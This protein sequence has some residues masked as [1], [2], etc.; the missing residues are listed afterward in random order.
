MP[1]HGT[2]LRQTMGR[3]GALKRRAD[4]LVSQGRDIPDS[5]G[6]FSV[7]Q[8]TCFFFVSEETVEK[9]IS[10]MPNYVP[11]VPVHQVVSLAHGD[12]I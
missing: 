11:P 7:F 2:S 4:I 3:E 1:E 10:E 9:T 6:L 5:A 8:E 12:L